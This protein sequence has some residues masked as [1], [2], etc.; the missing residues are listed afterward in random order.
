VSNAKDSQANVVIDPFDEKIGLKV[1]NFEADILLI[2]HHHYDHDNVRAVKGSP[3]VIDGPGEY[4]I[5]GV[6]V[7][8]IFSF[9][10]GAEGK[11]RGMNTIYM[12][13]SEGIRLCHLGD[14][15]QKELTDE[16]LEK[17]GIVDVL[18]IP[19]GGEF[20]ID[21][22]QAQK[23]I[24]Q[25]EPKMVIPMHY[26]LPKLKVKLDDVGKFLKAMGKNAVEPQD[27]LTV[28]TS[29]LP[30]EGEMEIVVLKP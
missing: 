13:E 20:T 1:P 26:E 11:E 14:L 5:K 17:I 8:G 30:K 22:S 7:Q 24:G 2:T 9:H 21:S 15:G 12:I 25:V 10:D 27:K 28:K 18:M 23:I 29:T 3:F 4:E 16:Q 6:F 19:V